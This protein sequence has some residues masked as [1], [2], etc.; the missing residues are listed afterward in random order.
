MGR[1]RAKAR[2]A[3]VTSGAPVWGTA[4]RTSITSVSPSL[5]SPPPPPPPPPPSPRS[6]PAR[7]ALGGAGAA[8]GCAGEPVWTAT[9]TPPVVRWEIAVKISQ[10][11][12][13]LLS[14]AVAAV[15]RLQRRLARL[16]VTVTPSVGSWEIAARTSTRPAGLRRPAETGASLAP[17]SARPGS[18]SRAT[19][20][21]PSPPATVTLTALRSETAVQIMESSAKQ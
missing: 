12:A 1:G 14:P 21:L 7:G 20:E 18:S 17:L 19:R 15:E 11:S 8:P 10:P 6:P 13:G 4:V 16:A 5:Q 2:T 3:T 9:V